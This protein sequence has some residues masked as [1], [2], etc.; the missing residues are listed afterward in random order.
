MRQVQQVIN[1]TVA[2][3][4]QGNAISPD[5]VGVSLTTTVTVSQSLTPVDRANVEAAATPPRKTI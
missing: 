3:P 4:L 5:L 2:F 1:S